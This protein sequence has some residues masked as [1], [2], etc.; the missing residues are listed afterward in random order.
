MKKIILVFFSIA[1]LSLVTGC[2]SFFEKQEQNPVKEDN[3][4]SNIANN[5]KSVVLYFSA[6]GNT[7]KV[8]KKISEITNSD[9][10]EILPN[11]DYTNEDLKYTDDNCRANKEQN[12]DSSRPKI[13]NVIDI[14]S[15]D[16]VFLGYPIWWGTNPR[17]I[18]TLLDTVDFSG[19]KV[20]LFSTSSSSGIEKSVSDLKNYKQNL[21]I[22]DSKRFSGNETKNEI[23][24]WLSMLSINNEENKVYIK[25]NNNVLSASLENNSS[26]KAFVE[27]LKQGDITIKMSDYG[28]FEKVGE[29]GFSL[30]ANDKNIT[31]KPGD[32]ILYQ[33]DKITIYYDTNTWDFTKLGKIDNVNQNELKNILGDGDVSVTFSLNK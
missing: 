23:E 2:G 15:Y 24:S 1:F 25:I 3:N 17:I 29:L 22:I 4:V 33:K 18:L 10:V 21:D 9:L 5:Y 8:S 13:K 32:I 7:E 20:V 31:T 11:K 30:P 19:K 16:V 14:S 28:N 6:T 27:K 12:D 26:S